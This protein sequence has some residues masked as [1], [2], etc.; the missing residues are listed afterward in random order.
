MNLSNYQP[1]GAVRGLHH[2]LPSNN[3]T[4]MAN[5]K[6]YSSHSSNTAANRFA[7]SL[8]SLKKRRHMSVTTPRSEYT[9]CK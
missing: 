3:N 1:K 4:P 9:P 8:E 7:A 2:L 6:R 5:S